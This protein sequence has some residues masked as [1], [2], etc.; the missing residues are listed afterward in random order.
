MQLHLC[1]CAYVYML[2][3]GRKLT[4]GCAIDE[5][6]SGMCATLFV[7]CASSYEGVLREADLASRQLLEGFPRQ[8]QGGE[9]AREHGHV[10]H[11]AYG[12]QR[13]HKYK[14]CDARRRYIDTHRPCVNSSALQHHSSQ[15]GRQRRS[16]RIVGP[17]ECYEMQLAKV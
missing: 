5:S 6:A 4:V 17:C 11:Q 7:A 12:R 8:V 14:Q 10:P 9:R 3:F 2:L 1:A 16:P 15:A 13:S